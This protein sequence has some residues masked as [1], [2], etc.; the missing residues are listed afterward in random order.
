[1]VGRGYPWPVTHNGEQLNT[2]TPAQ[3]LANVL[4]VRWIKSVE[5]LSYHGSWV[6]GGKMRGKGEED[7]TA[8]SWMQ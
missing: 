4:G 2:P 1:M 5:G 3:A 8:R 6:Q 7:G